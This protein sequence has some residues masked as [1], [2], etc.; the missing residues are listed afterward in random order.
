MQMRNV[1]AGGLNMRT[2]LNSGFVMP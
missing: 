1:T 2:V